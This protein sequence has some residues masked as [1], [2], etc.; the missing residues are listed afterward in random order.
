[1]TYLNQFLDSLKSTL[2]EICSDKDLVLH[3][4]NI[5]RSLSTIH[6]M[7]N[8]GQIPPYFSVGNYFYYL[9]DDV[10]SWLKSCYQSNSEIEQKKQSKKQ[11]YNDSNES[12]LEECVSNDSKA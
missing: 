1:M 3:V 10:I 4:P 6:R 8:R 12:V 5:F 9:R 11:S 2:P 7:R